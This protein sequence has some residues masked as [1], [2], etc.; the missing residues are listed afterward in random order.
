VKK[1]QNRMEET[2]TEMNSRTEWKKQMGKCTGKT[3][4]AQIN[5]LE[6]AP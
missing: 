1:F 3:L 5:V 6:T 4:T 2:E